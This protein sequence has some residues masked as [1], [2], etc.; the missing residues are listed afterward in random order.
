MSTASPPLSREQLRQLLAAEYPEFADYL[1]FLRAC[2]PAVHH[3]VSPGMD[4]TAVTNPF[5]VTAGDSPAQLV[6]TIEGY[7]Q[8][9][10]KLP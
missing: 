3:R 10:R 7:R 4:R 8:Q 5:L 1:A 6:A 9:S 2:F